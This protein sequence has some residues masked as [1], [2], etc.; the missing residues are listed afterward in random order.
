MSFV[1]VMTWHALSLE[2]ASVD[3]VHFHVLLLGP[4]FSRPAFYELL[5]VGLQ[6]TF[7]YAAVDTSLHCDGVTHA[8]AKQRCR[9]TRLTRKCMAK[10]IAYSPLGAIKS[11]PANTNETHLLT[12][13]RLA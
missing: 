3:V 9:D 5:H 4:S 6:C 10:S 13:C 2:I 8:S 12:D 11:P 7:T 1:S